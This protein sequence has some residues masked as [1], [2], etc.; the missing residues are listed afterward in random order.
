MPAKKPRKKKPSERVKPVSPQELG[1]QAMQNFIQALSSKH[2]FPPRTEFELSELLKPNERFRTR[3]LTHLTHT[4]DVRVLPAV[5]KVLM[6]DPSPEVRIQAVTTFSEPWHPDNARYLGQAMKNDSVHEVRHW[7]ARALGKHK[8]VSAIQPLIEAFRKER[9][10]NARYGM[11]IA[12]TRM[13]DKRAVPV[14]IEALRDSDL[15]VR[16]QAAMAL[17]EVRAKK[18]AKPLEYLLSH[19]SYNIA[20]GNAAKAL[21]Q[22]GQ[23]KSIPA[24]KKALNDK[25]ANV[26]HHAIISLS[27]FSIVH[28][29]DPTLK[30]KLKQAEKAF[31]EL[32]PDKEAILIYAI[33]NDLKKVQKNIPVSGDKSEADKHRFLTSLRRD[34]EERDSRELFEVFGLIKPKKKGLVS[35]FLGLFRRK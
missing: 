26:R 33:A 19:D 32:D 1:R 28:A 21:G 25:D 13:R 10:G 30:A 22:I 23:Q 9:H 7:A 15:H 14:L 4:K 8:G 11:T 3:A 12:L 29:K 6:E 31:K 16:A 20:R 5:S 27:D 2:K 34:A 35:R 18:A 17:G 24:L